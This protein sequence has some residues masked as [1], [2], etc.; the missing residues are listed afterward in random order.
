MPEENKLRAETQQSKKRRVN[1]K[2]T[3]IFH[4]F[5][6]SVGLVLVRSSF[7]FVYY[8]FSISSPF[9]L[10]SLVNLWVD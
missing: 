3:V 10:F 7:P 9:F 1:A 5:C 4:L 6:T 2:I 8:P